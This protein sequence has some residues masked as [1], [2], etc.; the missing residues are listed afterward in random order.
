METHRISYTYRALCA[1]WDTFRSAVYRGIRSSKIF[2]K[3]TGVAVAIVWLLM[4]LSPAKVHAGGISVDPS[5]SQVELTQASPSAVIQV[6]V[7][8]DTEEK[9]IFDIKPVDIQQIDTEGNIQLLEK[10]S[11]GNALAYAEYVKLSTSHLSLDPH[12][13]LQVSITLQSNENLSPGGHYAAILFRGSA[14]KGSSGQTV[15]PALTTFV[16]VNKKGGELYHISLSQ[17]KEFDRTVLFS[18]PD[19]I[20]LQFNNAGNTHLTPHGLLLARDLFGRDIYKG[21]INEGSRIVLPGTHR[22]L[23]MQIRQLR[24]SF[25]LMIYRISI[26]G[27]TVPGDVAFNQE[28]TIILLSPYPLLGVLVIAS[29]GSVAML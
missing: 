29:I 6:T 25:P 3:A 28:S 11:E 9:E 14:E 13:S 22:I 5:F 19:I 4:F 23:P 1:A 21:I 26:K 20:R 27:D 18:F 7:K 2:P 24:W 15:I 17:L 12:S 10:P 8:N 16:L